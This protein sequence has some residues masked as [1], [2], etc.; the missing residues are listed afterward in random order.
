MKI[1]LTGTISCG[2]TT[3]VNELG[4]LSQF[5]DYELSTERSKYLRDLG[6]KL[7]TDSTL[8]GQLIFAAERSSEL[9]K[10]NI[11]TDRSIYDICAFTLSASSIDWGIKRQYV[12]LI[13]NLKNNYDIIIYVSPEG[14]EIENNNVRETN[15]EYR[16]KIDTV[17]IELLA[18]YPPKKLIKV[19]GP[20]NERINTILSNI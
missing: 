18:E 5:K 15:S 13:M 11:I 17:I 14:V 8:L 19:S 20:I 1:G 3:L 7:N 4:K 12:E 2:K 9:M 6:I 10:E 16:D